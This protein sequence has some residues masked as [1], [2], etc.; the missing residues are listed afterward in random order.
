VLL[1]LA[2]LENLDFL[3]HL[4]L[5]IQIVEDRLNLDNPVVP[6]HPKQIVEGQSHLDN[7]SF[8]LT[9]DYLERLGHLIQIVEGLL[10]LDDLVI[11]GLLNLIV[12]GLLYLEDLLQLDL[13]NLLVLEFQYHLGHPLI[14]Q[15]LVNLVYLNYP[16][17]LEH[18]VFLYLELL[19]PLEIPVYL[20]VPEN[21]K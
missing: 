17:D 15:F 6:A 21:Q 8:Q 10:F 19:E 1:Y 4:G 7:L 11:L 16:E 20:A 5:L 3:V 18:P 9:L 2:D 14:H 13:G 12:G